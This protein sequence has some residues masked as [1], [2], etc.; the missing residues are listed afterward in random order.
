MFCFVCG[1]KKK[2]LKTSPKK[3]I[4][5]T[6]KKTTQQQPRPPPPNPR[7]FYYSNPITLSTTL[8]PSLQPFPSL[9]VVL[10]LLFA[11]LGRG[12][13]SMFVL[14]V[15]CVLCW[16]PLGVAPAVVNLVVYEVGRRG[17]SQKRRI[18]RLTVAAACVGTFLGVG[19]AAMGISWMEYGGWGFF[20]DR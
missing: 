13:L 2:R 7:S 9:L 8:S 14:C 1:G 15:A 5:I 11:R 10:S 16:W 19:L 17:R 20:N 3:I 12:V 18:G 6:T 4:I